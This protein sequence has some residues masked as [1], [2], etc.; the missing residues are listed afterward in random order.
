MK[1]QVDARAADH[2]SGVAGKVVALSGGTSGIGLATVRRL[3]SDG[4]QVIAIG[5]DRP[6][7]EATEHE[8]RQEYPDTRVD[9]VVADLSTTSEVRHAAR[10]I[11]RLLGE[12]GLMGLDAL[13]NNAAGVSTWR[14]V[15][16][17]GYE[18]QFAVNHLA[19]FLLTNELLPLLERGQPGRVV[20]VSSGSHR[21]TRINWT[22]P[23][24]SH[25]YTTLRAYKQSKL[26][27]VLFCAEFNRRHAVD[28]GVRAY[29]FDPGLVRTDIGLKS[30]SGIVRLVWR[31]R[32]RSR[33]ARPPEVPAQHLAALAV[34]DEIDRPR[35]FYRQLGVAGSAD[36]AGLDAVSGARLWALSERLCTEM[37]P[38]GS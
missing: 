2:P 38:V 25:G 8:L 26:S 29:A 27:N 18:R 32:S 13:V 10:E 5:R 6:R 7:C 37:A 20:T 33:A 31:L 15:T 9:Y 1:T 22:D 23:M 34:H 12:Y 28:S 3:L 17:E 36:P 14:M 11:R 16:E 19:G 21:H 4:V 35:E 30:S 24:L